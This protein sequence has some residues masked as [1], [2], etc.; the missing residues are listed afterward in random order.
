MCGHTPE[1]PEAGAAGKGQQCQATEG[2]ETAIVLFYR[3]E[4]LGSV[5]A[6]ELAEE[7][8]RLGD[9]LQLSG[10]VLVAAEGINGTVQGSS[11]A[12]AAYEAAVE[13]FLAPSGAGGIDWK[14]SVG[15]VEALFPDFA[16]KEVPELVGF[17]LQGRQLPGGRSDRPLDVRAETG[18]HLSPQDFH[19]LL[20]DTSPEELRLL[21]VRNTFEHEV[22]HFDGSI[23]PG[24]THTAQW[25]RFV[26]QHLE[27]LRG[28]RVLMYCTGGIRCEKAS[29]YLCRRLR[30]TAPQQESGSAPTDPEDLQ[31]YQLEG[32]IH[33]YF[34][35]FPDGGR[36]RGANFTFDRRG[37]VRPPLADSG[38]AEAT[39]VGRCSE[40]CGPWDTHH[41]GRVCCVCR[42]L[43]LVCDTCDTASAHGEYYCADHA[44]LRGVYFHFTSSFGAEALEAQLSGLRT[45][46]ARELG[47]KRKNRRTT[48][49]KKVEQVEARL[50]LLRDQAES[51]AAS[52]GAEPPLLRR[53]RACEKPYAEC[54]GACWGFW[55]S[56]HTDQVMPWP[57]ACV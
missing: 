47:P 14:R 46:L 43:V 11:E 23:D 27:E 15:G 12:V 1:S 49:R 3:Y 32:G 4:D 28:K 45:L 5:R 39:V 36:F 53:C 22:G 2:G 35:A 41:G 40:C 13:A 26:D 42:A 57:Q 10:R 20:E 56:P 55:R 24:M 9:S 33:R 17:G 48:L 19:K 30:E 29:A 8:R 6:A 44:D 31:V 25:P 51:T 18:Q 52:A 16:V 7:Q 50:Q 34:E 21:D 54:P 37:S 38:S